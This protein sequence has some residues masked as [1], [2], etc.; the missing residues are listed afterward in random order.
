M[1]EGRYL[2]GDMVTVD[3]EPQSRLSPADEAAVDRPVDNR[4]DGDGDEGETALAFVIR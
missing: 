2:E 1:L 3:V 4:D